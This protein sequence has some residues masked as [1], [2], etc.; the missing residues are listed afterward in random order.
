MPKVNG[1]LKFM[2]VGGTDTD[3]RSAVASDNRNTGSMGIELNYLTGSLNGFKLGLGFQSAH[4]LGFHDKNIPSEDDPRNS[5]SASAMHQAFLQ[6]SY[7]KMNLKVGRQI[8]RSPLLLNSSVF[9]MK[10][11]FDGITLESK[12]LPQ[13]LVKLYYV[14]EW[15][16]RYGSDSNLSPIQENVHYNDRLYSIYINNKSIKNLMLDGQYMTTNQKGNNGN[17]PVI[18]IDGYDHYFARATYKASTSFPL[19]LGATYGGANYD[20]QNELDTSFYGLKVGTKL[21]KLGLELAYTEVSEDNDFPGTLGHVPD[22]LLYTNMLIN[23]AIY[24]GVKGVSL[25]A[26]Y[27]IDIDGLSTSAKIAR[28]DQSDKGVS[29]SRHNIG[30]VDELNLDLKYEFSGKLKGLSTRLFAGHAKYD[31]NVDKDTNTYAQFFINYKF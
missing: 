25:N 30:T 18:V 5:I 2:Y 21:G 17:P 14:Q 13:T 29:N 23:K 20:R 31:L 6:Y 12:H 28:L 22:T 26:N 8:M 1:E 15:N 24:A 16:K 3:V 4:D 19:T 7:D 9:P 11:S 27:D 10:D